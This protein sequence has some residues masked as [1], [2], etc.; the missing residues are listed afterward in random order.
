[1]S[2][3]LSE[4]EKQVQRD[5]LLHDKYTQQSGFS[6]E[7]IIGDVSETSGKFEYVN[8][9]NKA[10][11][12]E[13][14]PESVERFSRYLSQPG[15]IQ[16][17]GVFLLVNESNNCRITACST[18]TDLFFGIHFS[19]ILGT[20]LLDL[21]QESTKLKSVLEMQDLNLINP[22]ILT[23]KN[24]NFDD[25]SSS[26]VR[27][28]VIFQRSEDGLL[29][30]VEECC[31]EAVEG[32]WQS[33]RRLQ[34]TIDKLQHA[35]TVEFMY[36][37]VA[38]D[39]FECTGYDRVMIYRF[40]ED[41]HGEVVAECKRDT[42]HDSW[43]GL[44]YPATDIPQRARDLF[45]I[46]RVR[47]ICDVVSKPTD[48]ISE[49]QSHP[50]G[51]I[52]LAWSTLRAVHPCHLEYLQNMGVRASLSLAVVVRGQLWGLVVCHHYA[53]RRFIPYQT[54]TAC[55]FLAQAF[56]IRLTGITEM[57]EHVQSDRKVHIHAAL[58]ENMLKGTDLSGMMA[59]LCS[60]KIN[61][62]SLI[63]D[64]SGAAVIFGG[65]TMT[66]GVVPPP[67]TIDAISRW[68]MTQP[69]K[70]PRSVGKITHEIP[71]VADTLEGKAAGVLVAP[72]VEEGVLMWFRPEFAQRIR[73]AG[74]PSTAA[75]F[76]AG[77]TMTPRGSFDAFVESVHGQCAPWTQ[78]NVLSAEGLVRLV[79]EVLVSSD[80]DLRSSFLLRLNAELIQTR[81]DCVSVANELSHLIDTAN[82][83]IFAVDVGGKVVQW[84]QKCASLSSMSQDLVVG[85]FLYDF[86]PESDRA[87][88]RD[89]FAR[90]VEGEETRTFEV[91]L[92]SSDLLLNASARR[93][94]AGRVTG[95]VCVGQDITET[96]AAMGKC[97]RI[98]EGYQRL[99]ETS[100]SP[101]FGVD[102]E[103]R[104][105][106]W[107]AAMVEV[108]GVEAA[109]V[110]G[111]LMAG[112]VFGSTLR[113]MDKSATVRLQMIIA[114]ALEGSETSNVEFSFYSVAGAAVELLISACARRSENEEISGAV[115]F[116][117]DI[118]QRKAL[119]LANTIRLAAEAASV[120]KTEQLGFLCHE[121][122]NP[123][124]GVMGNI[125]FL[126]ESTL[127]DE[128]A[129]L[130]QTTQQCC[131]QVRFLTPSTPSTPSI[132]HPPTD[133]TRRWPPLNPT[134]TTNAARSLQEAGYCFP[135]P[136]CDTSLR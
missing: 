85:K 8:E 120:A 14:T 18:N 24:P 71:G 64:T 40:H 81:G 126:E 34:K 5:A 77:R 26:H 118:T 53:G 6:K 57:E 31:D 89:I 2:Q 49:S 1:M 15:R 133:P 56:S 73:W 86:V 28:N 129:E 119:E 4:R 13:A 87:R 104:V 74:D 115:F 102:S 94:A 70:V 111:K 30:D 124:N 63:P 117:Q 91:S 121:I 23:A 54:R 103:A 11:T 112:E 125:A 7:G 32:A 43:L 29:V 79:E 20:A 78:A 10:F 128:Q 19:S 21:F 98:A 122:R 93:N 45:K 72:L 44:H 37:L 99:I 59:G 132:P 60:A 110:R 134:N 65:K 82:A 123:L 95:I 47:I 25:N 127:S 12:L 131:T 61:M 36:K 96:N 38:N 68:S 106:E 58:S 90:A 109:A 48:I 33:H 108:T 97:R 51:A 105:N 52:S 16:E 55:E 136:R 67:E 92:F 9:T 66:C 35:S 50:P 69:G 80:E 84:N 107:N 135:P 27:V 3:N 62:C 75:S 41:C 76:L 130:V 101:I 116:A 46:N 39:V 22:V 88:V 42:V 100:I 113:L 114:S 17:H 83:P